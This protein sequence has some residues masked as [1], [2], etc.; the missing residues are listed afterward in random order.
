MRQRGRA[1][2]GQYYRDQLLT[3]YPSLLPIAIA[4]LGETGSHRDA[5]SL[6]RYLG[7]ATPRI[8]R[9]TVKTVAA[10]D[11]DGNTNQ[12]LEMVYDPS[13]GVSV[14]AFKAIRHKA[15]G[16]GAEYFWS[17][18]Q[19]A[20]TPHVRRNELRL[21]AATSKWDGSAT[22]SRFLGQTTATSPS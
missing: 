7:H 15:A 16:I 2:F 14:Q 13:P 20:L 4:G 18:Y 11:A 9:A 5:Q 12:L 22:C 17:I 19:A 10:L 3:A 1:D 8:R 21:I 6:I